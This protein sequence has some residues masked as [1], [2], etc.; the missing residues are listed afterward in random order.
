MVLNFYL[1]KFRQLLLINL[2]RFSMHKGQANYKSVD[3][4]LAQFFVL[5]R[6]ISLKWFFG[7]TTYVL[8]EKL[9]N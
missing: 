9:E 3:I 5:K 8:V 4:V 7:P 1:D 6:T 2:Y